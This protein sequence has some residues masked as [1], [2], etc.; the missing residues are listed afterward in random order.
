MAT[1]TQRRLVVFMTLTNQCDKYE[2]FNVNEVNTWYFNRS[3]S[4]SYESYHTF[5]YFLCFMLYIHELS[6]IELFTLWCLFLCSGPCVVHVLWADADHAPTSHKSI[7]PSGALS[8]GS[9]R[10]NHLRRNQL[11]PDTQVPAP[12]P[13]V[14]PLQTEGASAPLWVGG[15]YRTTTSAAPAGSHVVSRRCTR[16]SLRCHAC[17]SSSHLVNGAA[18]G[19]CN[20]TLRAFLIIVFTCSKLLAAYYNDG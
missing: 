16:G 7:L 15:C 3:L 4:V 19:Y 2:L 10:R 9:V 12:I 1:Y 18:G 6:S 8:H 13:S 5:I 20:T 11:P 14:L 17:A